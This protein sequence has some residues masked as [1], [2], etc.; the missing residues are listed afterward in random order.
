VALATH[1][2]QLHVLAAA[3]GTSAPRFPVRLS[4]PLLAGVQAL[5]PAE[6]AW[7][8]ALWAGD[9]RYGGDASR[10]APPERVDG[11]R[12]V[13]LDGWGAALYVSEP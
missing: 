11:E 9:A 8:L 3:T 2:G 1:A 13:G 4:G 5:P 10:Q 7:R 6:G 12:A